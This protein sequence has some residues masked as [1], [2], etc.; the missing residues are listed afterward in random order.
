MHTRWIHG[1][2]A[3]LLVMVAVA[4]RHGAGRRRDE[5]Q[6]A[7][8]PADEALIKKARAI[9][10]RV[11]AL[12][13]H[14]DINPANFTAERNYTQDLDN[15][16]NLPK[17]VEGGLDA[18]FFIVYVGQGPLDAGR[19]RQRL[20]AGG[21]EVRR[22]PPADRAD[23]ARQDRAGADRRRR[24]AHQRDRQEGR[25]HRRRERLPARRRATAIAR[26]KEFYDR[27]APLHVAGAQ[28]PQPALR[29]EHRRARRLEVERPVAARQAGHRRDEPRRHHGRRLAS[30]EGVDDAGGRAVEGADHRLA[31]GACARSR[32]HS[33]NMD[34]EQLLALKKNGGVIQVVAFSSLREDRLARAHAGA[35]RARAR[36]SGCRRARRSAAVA[37]AAAG[38]RGGAPR[39]RAR[40]PAT[41]ARRGRR[42]RRRPPGRRTRRTRWRS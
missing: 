30:V 22:H 19:L 20:Q 28:R 12:D 33:R 25:A 27:G 3:A 11:I 37:D 41:P 18:S 23:R 24:P 10:E 2:L 26:V 34:D 38:R 7:K 4:P 9:H 39:T 35:R 6:A 15:Q 17:M 16:V 21:R 32:D 8:T 14:N 42:R 13:T 1:G 40:R 36:S 31:L 29:L 5:R